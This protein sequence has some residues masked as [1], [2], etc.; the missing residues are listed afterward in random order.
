MSLWP[1]A[2]SGDWPRFLDPL[3]WV[4]D[5]DKNLCRPAG[6]QVQT[7]RVPT[8]PLRFTVGYSISAPAGAGASF[9]IVTDRT[10]SEP[11]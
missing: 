3:A 11:Y 4:D 6:A 5:E 9:S 10:L 2:R 1:I 7:S 8:V